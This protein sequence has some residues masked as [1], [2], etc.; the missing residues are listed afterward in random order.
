MPYVKSKRT[1]Y[2]RFDKLLSRQQQWTRNTT[3]KRHIAFS[4]YFSHEH[5]TDVPQD[6][7]HDKNI[8][9]HFSCCNFESEEQVQKCNALY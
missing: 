8:T 4:S 3:S 7:S 5:E 9:E 1:Y 2:K 6:E